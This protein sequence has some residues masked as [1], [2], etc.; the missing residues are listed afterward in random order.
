MSARPTATHQLAWFKSS[1]SGA[2][3]TECVEC[4]YLPHVALIRD[5]KYSSGPTLSVEPQAWLRFVGSVS[6]AT[7][8][9]P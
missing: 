6:H 5:S 1:Y 9:R 2:N 8:G 7:Q 3:T 4:A